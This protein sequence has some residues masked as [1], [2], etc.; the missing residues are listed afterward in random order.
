VITPESL[1]PD[2]A[3]YP[4]LRGRVAVVTGAAAGIGQ[5]IAVRLAVE[6]M[7]VVLADINE[8]ALEATHAFFEGAGLS[9]LPVLGDV[10]EISAID[11][12][13]NKTVTTF[14]SVDLLVNNA[15]DLQR[16]SVL[17]PHDDVLDLQ[18]GTNIR[19]PYICSQRAASIMSGTG[20]SIVNISSVGAVRAHHDGLP[21]DMT[22]GAIDAMTRAMAVDLGPSGVRVNAIA[23]GVTLT[24]RTSQA[25]NGDERIPLRRFGTVDDIGAMVA[26]LASGEAAYVTG[27][28]MYVDGGITSQLSPLATAL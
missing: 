8:S 14:G 28:V 18:I 9:G 1:S 25:G 26:F 12:L 16:K 6:G 4:E 13:F 23:P 2:R 20:G 17:E 11:S 5:G 10:T 22:K 27:Q 7:H 19:G 3:R 15:A 24:Y 21:Y